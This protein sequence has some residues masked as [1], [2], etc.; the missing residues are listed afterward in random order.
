MSEALF[1]KPSGTVRWLK[2]G[3][4]R[5]SATCWPLIDDLLRSFLM[6]LVLRPATRVLSRKSA[7]AIGRWCG[8]MMLRVPSSGGPALATMRKSFCME[9]TEA[10]RVAREYLA[11]PFCSFVVFERMLSGRESL[12]TWTIKEKNNQSVAQLRDSERPFIV[13]A[14]HFRRESYAAM[15]MPQFCPGSIVT[16]SLPRPDWSLHPH[17]IRMKVQFGQFLKIH[18]QV[19]PDHEFV[20]VGGALTKLLKHLERPNCRVVMSVDTFWNSARASAHTRPFAGMRARTFSIGS[21]VLGRLAQCPIVPFASYVG[22]ESTIVLEWGPTIPPPHRDD[23][24]ADIVNTNI[25]LDFLE[26]AIGSRPSQYTLY[27]GEER[28]WNSALEIWEDPNG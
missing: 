9:D 5:I 18:Q 8:S 11:Q 23:E 14:G 2:A 12:D 7:L 19:C 1:A 22:K 21:A 15:F 24:A 20:Y 17:N 16:V 10:Q 25:I 6:V 13:A 26:N 28:C 4:R 3:K 27:M